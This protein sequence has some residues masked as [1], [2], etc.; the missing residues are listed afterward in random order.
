MHLGE[1]AFKG[2]LL[3]DLR[4]IKHPGCFYHVLR[5]VYLHFNL[6]NL[7][8]E[9]TVSFHTGILHDLVN[10]ESSTINSPELSRMAMF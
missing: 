6:G 8:L 4:K 5:P 2:R 7:D 3:Q 10:P 9:V 1:K